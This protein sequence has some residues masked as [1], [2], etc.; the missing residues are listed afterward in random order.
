MCE[1]F[2]AAYSEQGKEMT[3]KIPHLFSWLKLSP[4][5]KKENSRDTLISQSRR[6]IAEVD[7]QITPMLEHLNVYK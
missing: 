4:R 2:A 6:L 3:Q 7:E 1:I 5:P